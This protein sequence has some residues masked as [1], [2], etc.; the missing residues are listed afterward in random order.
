MQQDHEARANAV[1]A[2]VAREIPLVEHML[3]TVR[4]PAF[5]R[6]VQL[7][8]RDL[9]EIELVFLKDIP[10][11]STP[12]VLLHAAE[13]WSAG[14]VRMREEYEKLVKQYGTGLKLI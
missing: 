8:R 6:R 11:S 4:D 5:T 7:L 14:L 2:L 3:A 13:F 10:S 9:G 12:E 1:R